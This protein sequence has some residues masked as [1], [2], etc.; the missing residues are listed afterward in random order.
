MYI[1]MIFAAASEEEQ[2]LIERAEKEFTRAIEAQ[3]VIERPL[4]KII[5]DQKVSNFILS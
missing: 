3:R 1:L 4:D 5:E 2:E